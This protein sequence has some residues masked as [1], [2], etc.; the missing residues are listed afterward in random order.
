MTKI[1]FTTN[2]PKSVDDNCPNPWK[3]EPKYFDTIPKEPG[4]YIVGVKI[5]VNDPQ[6]FDENGKII[7]GKVE[8]FCP[9][10]VG[11]RNNLKSR[12]TAHRK[13]DSSSG[14]LNTN[15]ELFDLDI[16]GNANKLY[17]SIKNLLSMRDS[18]TNK[19]TPNGNTPTSNFP[20]LCEK[21][22]QELV[23][24]HKLKKDKN[25]LI[26]FPN[27]AFFEIIVNSKFF[28][29]KYKYH[30]S[31]KSGNYN[32]KTSLSGDLKHTKCHPLKDRIVE[33]KKI[34]EN[35]YWYAYASKQNNPHVDFNDNSLLQQIEAATKW[36]LMHNHSVPTYAGI[37]GS[38]FPIWDKLKN[39][40]NVD[41]EINLFDIKNDLVNMTGKPFKL[42]INGEFI[43]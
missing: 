25:L 21:C 29:S 20:I 26:W 34:I 12:I 5:T 8:K 10:Y 36:K 38:G 6:Q 3:F 31:G 15:K 22:A 23:M 39:N 1:E 37:N 27:P 19:H 42:D 4:V 17:E 32:H 9:L 18:I 7:K 16:I 13:K 40:G 11:I 43:I 14:E 28:K 41:I 24:F 30:D 2:L 33:T 35:K